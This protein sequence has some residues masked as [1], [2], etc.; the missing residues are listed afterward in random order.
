[1]RAYLMTRG[2]ERR[3]DYA[4]LGESPPLRWWQSIGRW[5]VLEA[6][7]LVV[8][9][10]PGGAT[11]LLLSGIP[12]QRRDV[13][14]TRI[15]YTVVVDDVHEDPALA[16][17]LV[18]CGLA[19]ADRERLGQ[20][21]DQGFEPEYVDALLRDSGASTGDGS[22]QEGLAGEVEGRLLSILR[23]GVTAA[24][25]TSEHKDRPG[26]WVGGVQDPVARQLFGA[27]ARLLLGE[28]RPGVAF[29]T[30]AVGSVEGAQRAAQALSGAVT[31][32][33]HD[34]ELREIQPLRAAPVVPSSAVGVSGGKASA[35]EI[36]R[37]ERGRWR[38]MSAAAVMLLVLVAVGIWLLAG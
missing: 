23:A 8:S 9:R 35:P 21:L 22:A 11:G 16:D 3:L 14:G 1:M 12:S 24:P 31:V 28:T 26:P 13:I 38:A 10:L 5:L 17:W 15:R 37:G 19:D 34:S 30:H 36:P 25:A 32:L 4:Y 6:A 2:T 7:E 33:L 18:R 27:R 20:A 29:T